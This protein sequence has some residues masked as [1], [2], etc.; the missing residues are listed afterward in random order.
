MVAFSSVIVVEVFVLIQMEAREL[1]TRIVFRLEVLAFHITEIL[2][3]IR[4][5]I[6]CPLVL[7]YSFHV[8]IALLRDFILRLDLIRAINY[9]SSFITASWRVYAPNIASI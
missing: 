8:A 4:V 5:I 1:D 6:L 3:E 2:L 9:I 7:T